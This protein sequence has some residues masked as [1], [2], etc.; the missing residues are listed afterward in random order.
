MPRFHVCQ[1]WVPENEF[2]NGAHDIEADNA[3]RAAEV[4]VET[5]HA[6]LDY[7]SEV[8]VR[9]LPFEVPYQECSVF[10]V[11]VAAIPEA[12]AKERHQPRP[13]AGR[14][15]IESRYVD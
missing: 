3:K 5:F 10:D 2:F 11:S 13:P 7:Q 12:T 4:Y 8:E 14:R 9:V 15:F 1:E 6:D